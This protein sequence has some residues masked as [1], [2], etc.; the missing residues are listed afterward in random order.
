MKLNKDLLKTEY[1]KVWKTDS[2]MIDYCVNKTAAV[3]ELPD[4]GLITVDKEII[5]NRFCFGE[6]GFDY[7]E[8]QAEAQNAR[9][10]ANY[11]KSENMRVFSDI[12]ESLHEA[13]NAD[14]YEKLIIFPARYYSQTKDCKFRGMRFER[15]TKIID[16][17]GCSVCLSELPGKEFE[18]NGQNCHVATRE[19]MLPIIAAYTEAA[20]AHEKKIDAY[21]K[22]YG[23]S[24]VHAWT[25]WIDA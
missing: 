17:C 12:L 13:A 16:A 21:L 7:D 23:L 8:A 10:N 9:T 19:E 18:Y 1:A 24:K 6:Q 4:G 20:K 2:K 3:A 25:Y 5:E 15:L 22:R 14:S 11:F